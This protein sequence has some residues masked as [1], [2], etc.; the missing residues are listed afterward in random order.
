[1]SQNHK[2]K[3]IFEHSDPAL[4]AKLSDIMTK[5]ISKIE[6]GGH[7]YQTAQDKDE[8][9]NPYFILVPGE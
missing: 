9:G 7:T 5:S 2:A 6:I 3:R 8:D 4:Y 1:M